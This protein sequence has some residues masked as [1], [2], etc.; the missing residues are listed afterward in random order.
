MT[1]II[2]PVVLL[3]LVIPLLSMADM[4]KGEAPVA[5][6]EYSPDAPSVDKEITFDASSSLGEDL[7]FTWDFGDD[8]E[9]KGVIVNHTYKEKGEYIVVLAV[10][11]ATGGVDTYSEVVHVEENERGALVGILL[12]VFFSLCF[13]FLIAIP[14]T[15]GPAFEY[16]FRSDLGIQDI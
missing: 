4:V 2:V 3:A 5:Q 10:T 11:N 14:F 9:A 1:R 8:H 6:F 13:P 15:L 16:R 12:I 7:Q